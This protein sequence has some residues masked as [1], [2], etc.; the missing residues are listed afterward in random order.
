MLASRLS[1]EL[2]LRCT[3]GEAFSAVLIS[4][5]LGVSFT[6]YELGLGS[7]NPS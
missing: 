5:Y 6:V 3:V 4:I 7:G 1:S 2:V